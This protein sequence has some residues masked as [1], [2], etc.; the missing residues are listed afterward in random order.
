MKLATVNINNYVKVKLNE[1]GLSVMKSNREELQRM[2]PSLP[3]FTPPSTDSD[4]YSKFQLWSLME[5]F[6]PIIHLGCELPFDSE[7]LFTCESVTE[8]DE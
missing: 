4:G 5:T 3:D 2:A 8:V 6:G 7:I 1:F